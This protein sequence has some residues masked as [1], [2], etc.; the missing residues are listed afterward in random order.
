MKEPGRHLLP[1]A[2]CWGLHH[3]QLSPE[4]RYPASRGRLFAYGF[5]SLGTF[6]RW[7][8][9]RGLS[10]DTTAPLHPSPLGPALGLLSWG[11]PASWLAVLWVS[12]LLEASLPGRL[13]VPRVS[14][15][16]IPQRLLCRCLGKLSQQHPFSQGWGLAASSGGGRIVPGPSLRGAEGL[17]PAVV[18]PLHRS[19]PWGCG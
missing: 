13:Q 6:L 9:L 5:A 7:P 19:D 12:P 3:P 8:S 18:A 11:P 2:G 10:R 14:P 1:L 4:P 16:P 15:D 17:P